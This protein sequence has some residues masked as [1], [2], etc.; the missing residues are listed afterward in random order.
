MDG[1]VYGWKVGY[2]SDRCFEHV[3]KDCKYVQL[4]V[5]KER[6]PYGA[7]ELER[8]RMLVAACTT[9]GTIRSIVQFSGTVVGL[10]HTE[11][12]DERGH[13]YTALTLAAPNK[14]LFAGLSTG[15]VQLFSWPIG[16]SSLSTDLRDGPVE[17][18]P[19]FL[20]VALHSLPIK[21]MG[22]SLNEQLLFC[23]DTGGALSATAIELKA[24]V[25]R[26]KRLLE[27][28]NSVY[29]REDAEEI[30]PAESQVMQE[31]QKTISVTASPDTYLVLP[32][33]FM[34][35]TLGQAQELQEQMENLKNKTEYTLVQ[36]E[37]EMQEKIKT[38]QEKRDKE[39]KAA[40][41]KYEAIV[42]RLGE[43]HRMTEDELQHLTMDEE[44]VMKE[45]DA[46]FESELVQLYDQQGKL[47][48][49]LKAERA[50]HDK[51]LRDLDDKYMKRFNVVQENEDAAMS[52]W[53]NEYDKVAE[54][55]KTDGLKF[56]AALTQT[57]H[58]Y[59]TEIED[60][61]KK[62]EADLQMEAERTD[63]AH[64]ECFSYKQNLHII[65]TQIRDKTEEVRQ[66]KETYQDLENRLRNSIR[67][68]QNSLETL[69]RR[70]EVI[71]QKDL[72]IQ[73]LK[74]SQKHLEGFRF[75]LFYKVKDLEDERAP[76]GQQVGDLRDSVKDMDA[77]FVTAFRGK[78]K[79]E[80]RLKDLS[81]QVGSL[82]TLTQH[83]RGTKL[84]AEKATHRIYDDLC[85][86]L[87]AADMAELQE[88]LQA[89]L[90]KYAPMYKK[91]DPDVD[92]KKIE[93]VTEEVQKQRLALKKKTTRMNEEAANVKHTR[94]S[95][96]SKM[97]DR[98][99]KVIEGIEELRADK[100][101]YVKRVEQL[102]ERLI[103]LKNTKKRISRV[104][105]EQGLPPPKWEEESKDE[106][107]SL[108]LVHSGAEPAAA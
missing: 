25:P 40:A 51:V 12:K 49:L 64:K 58:E 68:F 43:T 16:A 4:V 29:A 89:V 86:V 52:E 33:T 1:C 107:P 59:K 108:P 44:K 76:L 19:P 46:K 65:D 24:H 14:V 80:A 56:E 81:S 92:P 101:Q 2:G 11:I 57:N 8:E 97:V 5:G 83:T 71:K 67:R 75:V 66:E 74:D 39:A 41:E 32:K 17:P 13:Q 103:E 26:A 36:K 3:A 87:L 47:L 28:A 23:A 95:D 102:G 104:R 69:Q 77:E 73:R 60:L 50:K 55:L 82:Q 99:M 35:E 9:D 70:E 6:V 10:L 63:A 20:E 91:A 96:M 37:Q 7:S 54:L 72:Q 61:Q 105:R 88:R 21:Y 62:Q 53:R 79:L 84:Q 90:D 78:Q 100:R 85:E 48:E 98:N 45:K 30:P 38:L 94:H 27:I 22:V 42:T 18:P 34:Y 93:Q 31:V 15:N 106:G